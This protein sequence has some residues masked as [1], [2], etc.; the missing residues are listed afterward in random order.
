[1]S[2]TLETPTIKEKL[3]NDF[4]GVIKSL[5]AW[6]GDFILVCGDDSSK[7]YFKNKGYHTLLN[8]D[9]ALII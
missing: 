4:K 5:G 6:G 1:M 3:F 2:K 9:D 7:E 8:F